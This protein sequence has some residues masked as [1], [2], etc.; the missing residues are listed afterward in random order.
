MWFAISNSS[1]CH[2]RTT[3]RTTVSIKWFKSRWG[4]CHKRTTLRPAPSIKRNQLSHSNVA[5]QSVDMRFKSCIVGSTEWRSWAIKRNW[6]RETCPM[7]LLWIV[8]LTILELWEQGTFYTCRTFYRN[9]FHDR[10]RVDT[11]AWNY[12]RIG[13]ILMR[14]LYPK[15]FDE[16]IFDENRLVIF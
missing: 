13:I 6:M 15:E 3:L 16:V 2:N 7:K 5:L 11:G 12:F 14:C 8:V 10:N 9:A 1:W 4:R